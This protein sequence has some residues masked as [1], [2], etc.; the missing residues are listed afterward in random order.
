[1]D[2]IIL[3]VENLILNGKFCVSAPVEPHHGGGGQINKQA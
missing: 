3:D 2:S 1:M